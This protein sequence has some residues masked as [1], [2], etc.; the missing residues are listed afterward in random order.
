MTSE[1]IFWTLAA[2]VLAGVHVFISKVISHKGI[3]ISLNSMFNFLLPGIACGV[4]LLVVDKQIPENYLPIIGWS[5]L[6]GIA[7]G[8]SFL[9]RIHSLKNID[10]VLFFPINK[11]LGPIIAV[12]GGVFIFSESLSLQNYLGILLSVSVPLLLI[13]KS[14]KLRQK[15]L[16]LGL[17]LLVVSTIFGTITHF[18]TKVAL[19]FSEHIFLCL[20]VGQLTGFAVS[21]LTYLYENKKGNLK[22]EIREVDIKYGVV[23][24][25]VGLLS[26]YAIARAIATGPI[27]IVYTIHAHYILIPIILSVIY[28]KEHINLQKVAAVVVSMLAISFLI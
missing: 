9:T 13:N 21:L 27:S 4:L 16:Y 22:I 24:A 14:E 28:Y 19:G 10:S 2:T 20:M 18:F 7:Y 1:A 6:G 17:G 3:N 26:L 12:V 25:F 11:I 23:T 8:I 5:V 15:H